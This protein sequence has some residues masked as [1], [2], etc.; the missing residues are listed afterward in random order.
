M[1]IKQFMGVFFR[2]QISDKHRIG[3]YVLSMLMTMWVVIHIGLLGTSKEIIKCLGS[4]GL[5][6]SKEVTKGSNTL[7]LNYV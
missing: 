6:C 2:D 1:R 4:F 5:N 3:Y 7:N